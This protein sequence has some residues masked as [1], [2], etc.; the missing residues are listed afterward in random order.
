MQYTNIVPKFDLVV[1]GIKVKELELNAQKIG[2][3]RN[4]FAKEKTEKK[5]QINRKSKLELVGLKTKRMGERAK[6]KPI[7][8]SAIIIERKDILRS[9]VMNS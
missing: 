8:G 9:T 2:N 6:Q 4:L 1:G 7:S 5:S 3:K